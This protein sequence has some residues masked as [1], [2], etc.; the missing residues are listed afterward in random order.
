MVETM[1]SPNVDVEV[2]LIY[3]VKL[4]LITVVTP[5]HKSMLSL[6]ISVATEEGP[7]MTVVNSLTLVHPG[8]VLLGGSVAFG[9]EILVVRL[10]RLTVSGGRVIGNCASHVTR[11]DIMAGSL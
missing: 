6:T 5:P 7:K 10:G 9:V 1:L 4:P 3:L 2:A 11:S 8:A